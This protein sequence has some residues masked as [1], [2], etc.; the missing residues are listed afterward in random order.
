MSEEKVEIKKQEDPTIEI[1]DTDVSI[2]EETVSENATE[3]T[4]MSLEKLIVKMNQISNF[5]ILN[6]IIITI[7][8]FIE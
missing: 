8:I 1:E 5:I 4:E 6:V 7:N 2:D 3:F